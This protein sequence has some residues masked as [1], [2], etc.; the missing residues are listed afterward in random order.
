MTSL[1]LNEH[2]DPYRFISDVNTIFDRIAKH[3]L[4]INSAF[5]YF[6][7]HGLNDEFK[8]TLITI[9]NKTYPSLD[10]IED[11]LFNAKGSD[12]YIKG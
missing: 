10:E 8:R 2:G 7:W 11:N 3:N 9:N 1:K 12:R 5:Q 4:D 6:L